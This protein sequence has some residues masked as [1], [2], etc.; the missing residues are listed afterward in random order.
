MHDL[1]NADEC[2]LTG[3]G[4]EIVPV[5]DVDGRRVGDGK[6]GPMTQRLREMYS[7]LRVEDGTRVD[8]AAQ[9]ATAR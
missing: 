4:A 2:F 6:P 9:P 7:V 8:Y 3:T 1:Y 5:I